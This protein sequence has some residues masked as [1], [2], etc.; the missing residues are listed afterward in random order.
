[1]KQNIKI[2][3]FVVPVIVIT[4]AL[5]SILVPIVFFDDTPNGVP[6]DY[7]DI[8]KTI[9]QSDVV[10]YNYVANDF[11]DDDLQVFEFTSPSDIPMLNAC[12]SYIII[13][14][15]ESDNITFQEWE[16]ISKLHTE[17]C[18]NIIMV[19]YPSTGKASI[20][21]LIDDSTGKSGIVFI[22]RDYVGETFSFSHN[23]QV[24]EHI[25]YIVMDYINR[26]IEDR[27]RN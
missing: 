6:N 21:A 14:Y 13:D 9:N 11:L 7:H 3:Y 15:K 17:G 20:D 26:E 18:Y 5:T 25:G 22:E 12:N 24:E 27:N 8:I 23:P 2:L 19:N 16:D 10:I 1:M 4:I